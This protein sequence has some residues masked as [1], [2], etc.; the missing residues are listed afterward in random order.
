MRRIHQHRL[1]AAPE[2]VGPLDELH[3]LRIRQIRSVALHTLGDDAVTVPYKHEQRTGGH[4]VRRQRLYGVPAR[5]TSR[6]TKA[7]YGSGTTP[8]KG[9]EIGVRSGVAVGQR[10][11]KRDNLVFFFIG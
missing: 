1:E 10:L 2:M 8:G 6:R 7:V 5:T 11:Q 3:P 9:V 4:A